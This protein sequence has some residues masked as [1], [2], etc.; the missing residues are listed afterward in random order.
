MKFSEFIR[1]H[2]FEPRDLSDDQLDGM[3][4][5]HSRLATTEGDDQAD[6]DD[7]LRKVDAT[8]RHA[9]IQVIEG[10]MRRI[11]RR[12]QQG[13]SRQLVERQDRC[14]NSTDQ[15]SR[16]ARAVWQV[17]FPQQRQSRKEF[18]DMSVVEQVAEIRAQRQ[19]GGGDPRRRT[20]PQGCGRK[21]G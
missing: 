8:A 10:S 21:E 18:S 20:G 7:D 6:G 16:A 2:G 9:R 19:A 15:V 17:L 5:W 13:D 11:P 1:S 14:G 3:A 4:E 12:A